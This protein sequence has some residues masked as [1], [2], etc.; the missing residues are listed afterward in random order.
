MLLLQSVRRDRSI[1]F[2]L[3]ASFQNTLQLEI[4]PPEDAMDLQLTRDTCLSIRF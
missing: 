2:F 3:S 1:V 4:E